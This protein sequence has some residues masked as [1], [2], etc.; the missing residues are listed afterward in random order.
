LSPSLLREQDGAGLDFPFKG[1]STHGSA[2]GGLEE[3][4][5]WG[6]GHTPPNVPRVLFPGS[7]GRC[8]KEY[9]SAIK[10]NE[11]LS[12]AGKGM[13]LENI[14]LSEV[15]Q[16]DKGHMFSLTCGRQIQ[17]QMLSYIYTYSQACIYIDIHIHMY[18]HSHTFIYIYTHTHTHREQVSNSGTVRGD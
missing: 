10:K 3:T 9:Y 5:A 7:L 14:M 13:E 17:I 4:Q 12:F 6:K 1:S 15:S 2:G 11:S 8:T 18:T 16:K